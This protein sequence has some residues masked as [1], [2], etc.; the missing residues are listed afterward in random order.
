[1]PKRLV[2]WVNFSADDIL[3]YFLFFFPENRISNF[4]QTVS[5]GDNLLGMSNPCFLK[6][7]R[8]KN[9]YLSSA[10]FAQRIVKP[11]NVRTILSCDSLGMNK[12]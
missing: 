2:L 11:G 4:M 7:K 3:K 10:E 12:R 9:I 1:M 5:N 6:K 8:K